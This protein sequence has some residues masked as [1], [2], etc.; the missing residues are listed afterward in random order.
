[1]FENGEDN[2]FANSLIYKFNT[3]QSTTTQTSMTTSS[4]GSTSALTFDNIKES[5]TK[6]QTILTKLIGL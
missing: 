4:L 3:K 6:D 1:V 5:I 2:C